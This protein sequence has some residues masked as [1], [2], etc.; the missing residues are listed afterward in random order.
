MNTRKE[1]TVKIMRLGC[2]KT[3]TGC[4]RIQT[5]SSIYRQLPTSRCLFLFI[6]IMSLK[7][8]NKRMGTICFDKTKKSKHLKQSRAIRI[9]YF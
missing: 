4:Y 1:V 6:K 2:V 5:K 8:H 7:L 3:E 9:T